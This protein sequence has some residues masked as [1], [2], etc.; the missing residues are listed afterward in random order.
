MATVLTKDF[1]LYLDWGL[2][3][4]LLKDQIVN[5]LGFA[6][7][8]VSVAVLQSAFVIGKQSQAICE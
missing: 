5:I 4:S 7:H 8:K 3:I 6:G 2:H 1:V